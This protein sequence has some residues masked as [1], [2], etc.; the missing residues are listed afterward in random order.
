V[1]GKSSPALQRHDISLTYNLA[2]HLNEQFKKTTTNQTHLQPMMLRGF[3]ST[4]T[5]GCPH[6]E[7]RPH[8]WLTRLMNSASCRLI[9]TPLQLV[10]VARFVTSVTMTASC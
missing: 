4:H 7:V 5:V 8:S 9:C 3:S 10:A 2:D 1:S 6:L